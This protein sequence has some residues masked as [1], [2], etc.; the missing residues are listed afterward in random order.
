[1]TPKTAP[2]RGRIAGLATA[3]PPLK[4]SVD[5]VWE[6]LS[7][8]RGRRMPKLQGGEGARTRHFAEPLISLMD[9][10]SQSQ[11]TDAYLRS[12]VDVIMRSE[13]W[14]R[15]RNALV[16]TFDEGDSTLGCCDANPGGG[17]VVTDRGRDAVE[18]HPGGSR[19]RVSARP[20]ASS[21]R[22]R[23]RAPATG[24]AHDG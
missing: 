13:V 21:P 20:R 9:R 1:M 7:T 4:A 3:V 16:V 24:G 8:A 5:E 2:G 19:A 12:T 11:Q 10:R 14:H 6:A 23:R 22:V 18:R 17:H 15:G